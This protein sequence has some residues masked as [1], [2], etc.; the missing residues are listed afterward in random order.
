M[1]RI[2]LAMII[3]LY[4]QTAS[5]LNIATGPSDGSYFQIAQDIKSVAA[6]EGIDLQIM[7]TKGSLEN[8]ELL[9]AGK[10]D[11]AIVQLDALRFIS[12]VAKQEAGLDV[13]E[14]IKVVM[15]LYPEEIHILTN[16]KDIQSFYQLEGKRVSVGPPGGGTAVTAA[17][18]FTVYDIKST[19]SEEPF[20]A[21]IKRMEQGTLDAVIFVG[22]APVPFIAKLGGK[23]QFVRLPSNPALEQIYLRTSLNRK[24][25]GWAVADTETYAVPSAIMGLD[26]RD[27]KYVSQMQQL[28]LAVL[29]SS[30]YL[31][32]SGHPKWKSS[33]IRTYFPLR[34]YEPTNQV[35]QIFDLLDKQGYKIIKK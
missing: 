15:N 21:A 6:K 23:F 32:T 26:K 13:F 17:V 8:I 33:I 29:N 35:I 34:G 31:N 4:A 5:A 27:E 24:Q 25:Y 3:L 30:E 22:G 12:D 10:V 18:L 2:V 14:R 1:K 11:L 7:P 16:K 19:V 28:V 9:G 20:E